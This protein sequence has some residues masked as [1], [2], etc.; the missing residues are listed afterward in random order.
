MLTASGATA[1]AALDADG[2]QLRV[3]TDTIN[4]TYDG[5]GAY[6]ASAGSAVIAVAP[7]TQ[8][9]GSAVF[10]SVSPNPVHARE[11]VTLTL[12]EQAGVGTTLTTLTMDGSDLSAEI[13]G[14]FGRANIAPFGRL[15]VSGVIPP[16]PV[17]PAT[18]HV[19]LG[20]RDADGRQWSRQ[21][22]V[23]IL[24]SLQGPA[25]VLSSAP[26]AVQ[27]D[28]AADP[29]CQWSEQ[30]LLQEQNGLPMQI[31]SFK[32]GA[33][34]LSG[35]IAR[36]FGTSH[37][38]AFGSLQATICE[39]GINPPQ[40][41]D[42]EIEGTDEYGASP[43]ATLRGSFAGPASGPAILSVSPP[44][45]SISVP[46]SG[47]SGTGSLAV[48]GGTGV[49]WTVSVFPSNATTA[50]LTVNPL[51]GTGPV[52]LSLAANAFGFGKGVYGATL[53]LRGTN[54]VPQF[55]EVPVDLVVG[56]SPA[57]RIDGVTN[58][59]SFQLAVAPGMLATV[60]GSQLA[61]EV[62]WPA[63]FPLPLQMSGV[64]ATINGVAAPLLYISPGQLNIQIPYEAG[65]GP[66]VV[67]VNVNGQV[68]FHEFTIA[69]SAP[70]IF[71]AGGALVPTASGRPGDTLP[72]FMTGEG[73]VSPFFGTNRTPPS[74]TPLEQLPRPVLPVTVTVGGL[75]A[76]VQFMGI[77]SGLLGAQIN[78]TIPLGATPGV[79]PLVVTVNGVSSPPVNLTVA[80]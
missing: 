13:P 62:R 35:Q 36:L 75:P 4:A 52:Q 50:W 40:T 55:L 15:S 20:G 22:T 41:L 45:V 61:P 69:P 68:A 33:V 72:L 31:T 11:P 67:G 79:Q 1:I 76:A 19:G 28:P 10:V 54:T 73:D 30:L 25:I 27:Q 42:Y 57:M 23:T 58:A 59:A 78:F 80:P 17:L 2:S 70:G 34:D 5:N 37:L 71:A 74:T 48:S 24:P 44:A 3:G 63:V 64:S 14:M 21:V 66:A 12:T 6:N 26:G 46:N 9:S 39:T 60:F 49:A 8:A 47:G 38:A 77:P 32:K 43:R 16:Q 65:A 18:L 29:S 56:E 7:Q 51:S 53:I